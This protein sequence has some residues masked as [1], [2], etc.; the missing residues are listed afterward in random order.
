MNKVRPLIKAKKAFTLVE[1]IVVITILAILWSIAFVSLQWFQADARD[2]KRVA[3]VNNVKKSLELFSLKAWKYP[4]PDNAEQVKYDDE[5]LWYQWTVWDNVIQQLS[6]NLSEKPLDPLYNTEYIYSLTNNETKYE[7]MSVYEWDIVASL[8]LIETTYANENL[9]AKVEWTYNWVYVKSTSYYVPLPS[10]ITSEEVTWW[11][12]L[13]WWNINSQVVNGKKNIPQIWTINRVTNNNWEWTIVNLSVYWTWV[14]SKSSDSIKQALAEAIQ[15]AYTWTVLATEGIYKNILEKTTTED[16]VSLVDTLVLNGSSNTS[17]E[18]DDWWD[19]GGEIWWFNVSIVCSWK[20]QWD[21]VYE[22]WTIDWSSLTCDDDIAVCS[23]DWT[24]YVIQSCNVWATVAWTDRTNT[25]TIWQHFQWWRN[26]WFDYNW[27]TTPTTTGALYVWI[28][29]IE[30]WIDLT[31]T[32]WDSTF[33]IAS[34]TYSYN[35]LSNTWTTIDASWWQWPCPENYHVPSKTEWFNLVTSWWWWSDWASMQTALKLPYT[36]FREKNGSF[37]YGGY[38]GYYWSSSPY[39]NLGYYM[40]FESGTIYSSDIYY[41][42][43]GVSVRCFK[44]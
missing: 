25:N 23:W 40:G 38:F 18:W 39:E 5:L 26:D 20:S 34:S 42:A 9:T 12:T 37:G 3:E 16:L 30:W 1:L 10:I 8:P 29:H 44:N 11:L 13:T 33:I 43:S 17:S 24:G 6:R 32:A 36:G 28:E 27:W 4:K 41:R 22:D 31:W 19:E 15:W 2:S 21:I 7:I 35:W 14:T